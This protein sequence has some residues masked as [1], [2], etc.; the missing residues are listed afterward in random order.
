MTGTT[1]ASRAEALASLGVNVASPLTRPEAGGASRARTR[2]RLRGKFP[3]ERPIPLNTR[4]VHAALRSH[5]DPAERR[6][7]TIL[8]ST[9]NARADSIKFQ[10]LENAVR[11]GELPRDWQASWREEYNRFVNETLDPEWRSGLTA[12]AD[13]TASRAAEALG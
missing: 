1:V 11:G 5:V 12:G 10:E 7:A 9:W 6:V 3:W 4:D 2:E 13:Y 8:Y